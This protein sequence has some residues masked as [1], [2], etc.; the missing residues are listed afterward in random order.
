[1]V[2]GDRLE[3][4][5]IA[6]TVSIRSNRMPP[7]G[8]D[9]LEDTLCSGTLV[10]DA[11][12]SLYCRDGKVS[13]RSTMERAALPMSCCFCG[14]EYVAVLLSSSRTMSSRGTEGLSSK[15]CGGGTVRTR[16][17][18][19]GWLL[20]VVADSLGLAGRVLIMG[21][22]VRGE[23]VWKDATVGISKVGGTHLGGDS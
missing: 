17:T 5:L 15:G 13:A 16:S 11:R 23:D 8:G 22:T 4:F 6:G 20:V 18:D 2:G 7:V 1:V 19:T 12:T 10:P 14:G 9:R 21:T 3:D